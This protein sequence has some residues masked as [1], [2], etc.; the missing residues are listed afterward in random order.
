M[1]STEKPPGMADRLKLAVEIGTVVVP[2]VMDIAVPL[3][4]DAID[5]NLVNS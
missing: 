5:R 3:I 1:Y 4:E 2:L